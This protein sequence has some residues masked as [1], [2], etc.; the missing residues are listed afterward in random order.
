[1]TNRQ[2]AVTLLWLRMTIMKMEIVLQTDRNR[3]RV[4]L[5]KNYAGPLPGREPLAHTD[6]RVFG[7]KIG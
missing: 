6:D 4:G 3:A 7:R 5:T 2:Q 1:M